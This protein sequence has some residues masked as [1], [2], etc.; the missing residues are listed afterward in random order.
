MVKKGLE[1]ALK[2]IKKIIKVSFFVNISGFLQA[3]V[4]YSKLN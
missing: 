3:S 4:V 2:K 1:R